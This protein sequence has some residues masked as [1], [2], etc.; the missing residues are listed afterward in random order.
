MHRDVMAGHNICNAVQGHLLKQQRP[1]HLQPM[2]INK[3]NTLGW[4]TIAALEALEDRE[5]SSEEHLLRGRSLA[6]RREQHFH[7]RISKYIG[8]IR[9]LGEFAICVAPVT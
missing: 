8:R 1:F 3:K 6:K 7:R 2:D 9:A 5:R 4:R